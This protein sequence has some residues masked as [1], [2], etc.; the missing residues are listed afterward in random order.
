[1]SSS[2][3]TAILLATTF[4]I[5]QPISTSLGGGVRARPVTDSDPVRHR[6]PQRGQTGGGD[7]PRSSPSGPPVPL[8]E[9]G[10]C[11][12][13]RLVDCCLGVVG[14]EFGSS[15]YCTVAGDE[16]V[17]VA[18]VAQFAAGPSGGQGTRGACRSKRVVG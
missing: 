17:G 4:A 1:M 3:L 10:P 11:V 13:L 7:R 12:K 14:F 15:L 9:G 18:P 6:G 5:H 16:L 8:Y 2:Q